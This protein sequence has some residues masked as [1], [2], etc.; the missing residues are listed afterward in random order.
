M[1]LSNDLVIYCDTKYE[2]KRLREALD[3]SDCKYNI[4]EN[5]ITVSDMAPE[6]F[7]K[8]VKQITTVYDLLIQ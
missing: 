5:R 1:F 8:F 6:Q 4:Y 2:R 7:M 3:F